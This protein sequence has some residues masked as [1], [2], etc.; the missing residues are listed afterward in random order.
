MYK[1]DV[2]VLN[3]FTNFNK[4]CTVDYLCDKRGHRLSKS[5]YVLIT[6]MMQINNFLTL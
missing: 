4:I 1:R 2:F 5:L 6:C 3:F